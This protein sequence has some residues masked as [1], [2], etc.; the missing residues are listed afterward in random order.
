LRRKTLVTI[1]AVAAAA[2]FYSVLLG[3]NRS[4]AISPSE[5][6]ARAE[7][8]ATVFVEIMRALDETIPSALVKKASGIAV[9]TRV[10]KGV[11]AVGSPYGKGLVAQRNGDGSW[12][13]PLFIEIR[14]GSFGRH[15]DAEDADLIIIFTNRSGIVPI[16]KGKLTVG[17]H[18]SAAA[19]P[20][21]RTAEAGAGNPLSSAIYSYSRSKGLLAGIALSG[22]VIRL[23][24]EANKSVYGKNSI[25]PDTGAPSGADLTIVQPFLDALHKYAHGEAPRLNTRER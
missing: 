10:V 19:G 17:P 12:A 2:I 18:A 4:G 13:T 5:E 21:G 25:R 11:S 9:I 20:I 7:N 24:D 3:Q 1:A 16:L 6:S 8:V 22:V 15:F 14:G 23:D